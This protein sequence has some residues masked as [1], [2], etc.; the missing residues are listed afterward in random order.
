MAVKLLET[1][2]A[3]VLVNTLDVTASGDLDEA[4][5][6]V[7]AH[8]IGEAFVQWFMQGKRHWQFHVPVGPHPGA[9]VRDLRLEI[10]ARLIANGRRSHTVQHLKVSRPEGR[11]IRLPG[12]DLLAVGRDL[13]GWYSLEGA[14]AKCGNLLLLLL[15]NNAW[16][17][18]FTTGVR[19]DG[20]T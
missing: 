6:I 5:C 13:L 9:E 8:D 18:Y 17:H 15:L 4:A 19:S 10:L 20:E 16:G 11:S 7:R 3:G 1:T 14:T 12:L 2:A